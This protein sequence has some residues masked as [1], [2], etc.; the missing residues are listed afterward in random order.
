MPKIFLAAD[1]AGFALKAELTAFLQE[2]GH[3]VEDCGAYE[4]QSDDDY[5]DFVT[6]CAQ[7]V[8]Q[9]PGSFG[10]VI[11]ASGQGEA[12][13]ANRIPGVRAAVFY[14]EPATMQTDAE[15]ASLSMLESTRAHNHAN[16]LSLAARFLTAEEAKTAVERF[17]GAPVSPEERHLRRIQKLG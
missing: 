1:H 8:A 11:G 13:A 7:K 3:T 2:R 10:I 12:M 6:P 15:G 17:L 14:G 4:E 5:P 16:V 9:T